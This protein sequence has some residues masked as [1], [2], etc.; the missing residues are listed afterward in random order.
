MPEASKTTGVVRKR[1]PRSKTKKARPKKNADRVY[2]VASKN[3]I[4]GYVFKI[5]EARDNLSV[6]VA[7]VGSDTTSNVVVGSRG[8]PTV[9]CVSYERFRPLLSH[10]NRAEK[11]AFL[12]VD[13]L[14]ADAPQH[15]RTPA[16]QELS[17]LSIGDLE[18]LWSIESFPLSP[19][20]ATAL[21]RKMKE[22]GA[23]DRLATRARVSQVLQEAR[24]AGLYEVLAD[25]SSNAVDEAE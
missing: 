15:I 1:T 4:P 10:G 12:V 22:P 24:E 6:I 3:K 13:E 25:A 7:E 21:K 19:Q 18:R 5:G 17:R 8:K 2:S 16:V 23:L 9:V 14:L 11:L 20:K